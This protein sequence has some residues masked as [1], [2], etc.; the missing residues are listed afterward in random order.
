[1]MFM[2]GPIIVPNSAR[3]KPLS[4]QR[5]A[6]ASDVTPEQIKALLQRNL[7]ALLEFDGQTRPGGR[8]SYEAL[9]RKAKIGKATVG[10]IKRKESAPA[11]DTLEAIAGVFRL[12]GWQLLCEDLDPANP[13]Q[14]LTRAIADELAELRALRAQVE[15]WARGPQGSE[16]SMGSSDAVDRPSRRQES[17]NSPR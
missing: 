15:A 6:Y 11:V 2:D 17:K 13:P 16:G 7:E 9:G 3:C 1:M 8:L 4:A 12:K 10:R 14:L 5:V